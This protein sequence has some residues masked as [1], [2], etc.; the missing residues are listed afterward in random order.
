MLDAAIFERD[1]PVGVVVDHWLGDQETPWQFG[2]DRYVFACVQFSYKITFDVGVGQHVVVN[3]PLK[4]VARQFGIRAV[5][6]F[7]C[8]RPAVPY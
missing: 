6:L 8:K 1:G 4:F 3:V 5:Q 2:I 7:Q